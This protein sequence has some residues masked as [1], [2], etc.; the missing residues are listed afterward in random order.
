MTSQWQN[1]RH[2]SEIYFFTAK[3]VLTSPA[4][5]GSGDQDGFTDI[6]ILRDLDTNAP[7]L[8]G[9]SLAGV[10]RNHLE[11]IGGNA[12]ELFGSVSTNNTSR[13][14]YIIFDESI[15]KNKRDIVCRKTV[16]KSI[17]NFNLGNAFYKYDV[18]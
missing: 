16:S 18:A 1:A 15:A 14:S 13:Q 17:V 10:I 4:I 3:L 11:Q 5:L 2:L 9:S 7:L 8:S 6:S 12:N